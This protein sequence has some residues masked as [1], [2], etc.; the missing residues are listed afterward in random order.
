EDVQGSLGRLGIAFE[1][2]G[3]HKLKN[4]QRAVHVYR[5]LLDQADARPRPP[6]P[7][8]DRP[9]IA[10]LPFQNMSGDP[11]QE[12]FA[13][14]MVEEIITGLSRFR[15]LFVIARNSSFTY[16]GSAVDVK[17]VGRELGVRYL[18]EGGVRKSANRVRITGQLIDASSGAH[19]WADRFEGTLEDVF[20]LQDQVT[21]NVLGAIAPRLLQAEI[22]RAR[23]EPTESR[24]AYELFLR[25][26]EN[27]YKW[28]REGNDQALRSFYKAIELDPDFSAAYA[29]AAGCFCRRKVSGWVVEQQQEI[30]EA[31]RLALRAVQLGKDDAIALCLDGYVLVYVA[32][33]LDEGAAFLDRCLLM[34]RNLAMGWWARGWVK[35]W[36]GECDRAVEHFARAMRL[37]PI[38]PVLFAMQQATAHAH[39]FAGRYDEALAWAKIALRELPDHQ[40]TLSVAAAS[41]VLAG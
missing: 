15:W 30:A 9:S 19:L 3:Q 38:D 17:Q 27:V 21:A 26:Q 7:L 1:D 12:Y 24:D 14:G 33:D 20:E 23:R 31:R 32:R 34:N 2:I 37:S 13:D 28:S 5:V 18:L 35:V 36:V 8:P 16:K 6:L 10:V 41:C 11:E 4:I 29:A 25:G 40:P 22:E 39:F